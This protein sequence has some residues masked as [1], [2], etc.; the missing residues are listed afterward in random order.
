MGRRRRRRRRTCS[1]RQTHPLPPRPAR[2]RGPGRARG[3]GQVAGGGQAVAG[4]ERGGDARAQQ[5]RQRGAGHGCCGRGEGL[6]TE[7]GGGARRQLQSLMPMSPPACRA[8]PPPPGLPRPQTCSVLTSPPH[9]PSHTSPPTLPTAHIPPHTPHHPPSQPAAMGIG[10]K[11]RGAGRGAAR[12]RAR[13]NFPSPPLLLPPSDQGHRPPHGHRPH[14]HP[15]CH[16]VRGGGGADLRSRHGRGG[17]PRRRRRPLQPRR[18][19]VRDRHHP[20]RLWGGRGRGR[21]GGGGGWLPGRGAG[22]HRLPSDW[23]GGED[24]DLPGGGRGARC[25]P[26]DHHRQRP[27]RRDARRR[28]RL[29]AGARVGAEGAGGVRGCAPLARA[30]TCDTPSRPPTHPSTH[31]PTHLRSTTPRPRTGPS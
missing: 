5:Q 15:L 7:R 17:H 23:R 4:G 20:A 24:R 8:V 26:A 25:G 29:R 16:P 10:D 28:R 18:R 9:T 3:G 27:R 13:S 1:R 31:P 22:R 14:R 11:A 2:R 21:G 12:Q 6:G 30:R 19:E